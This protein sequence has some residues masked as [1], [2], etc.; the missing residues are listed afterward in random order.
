MGLIGNGISEI[1]YRK[2]DIGKGMS[3]IGSQKSN[4]WID[5]L[6]RQKY[7]VIRNHESL[8]HSGSNGYI[9]LL[10]MRAHLKI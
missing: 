10:E 5:R 3:N 1:R 8:S 9:A 2:W 6:F 4:K 7:S